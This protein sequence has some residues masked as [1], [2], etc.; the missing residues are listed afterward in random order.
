MSSL[1][2]GG[3]LY[4]IDFTNNFDKVKKLSLK[5]YQLIRSP[6]HSLIHFKIN[7]WTLK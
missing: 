6:E 4:S 2:N 7:L 3:N 1:W 5:C